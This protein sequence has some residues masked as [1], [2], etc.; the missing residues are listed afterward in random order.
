MREPHVKHDHNL[1]PAHESGNRRFVWVLCGFILIAVFFLLMEHRA[2]VF[3]YLPWL[4]LLACP[5]LHVFMH[6]GHGGHG[7][8]SHAG[9][10]ERHGPEG[11]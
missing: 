8:G 5:L 11:R 10:D 2:H 6:R 9:H 3:G 1:R 7:G 4:L